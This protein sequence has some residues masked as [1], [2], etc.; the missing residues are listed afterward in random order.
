MAIII[1]RFI[2]NPIDSN[3]FVI[4]NEYDKNC[5]IIDPGTEDCS[6]ILPFLE[7][8][9]LEVEYC[10]LTHEHIDH[11]V[12]MKTLKEKTGCQV[13]CS[14]VCAGYL[15]D[16]KY[17]LSEFEERFEPTNLFPMA[18]IT[19]DSN[20]ELKWHDIEL[21]MSVMP[22]HSR[23]SA[24]LLIGK[25]LFVGDNLIKGIRTKANYFGGSKKDLLVTLE[26][27]IKCYGNSDLTVHCGH[28][29]SSPL[30]EMT[31]E[32]EEQIVFLKRKMK[33]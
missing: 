22:G 33:E 4:S 24:G 18:D 27:L 29:D 6:N 16:T 31:L 20:L 10:F 3:C 30:S 26:K 13:V 19:F 28:F 8:Y 23:G 5:V 25:D 11:I 17:N 12:G 2:N 21:K 14:S 32:I 1:H 7:A 9:G 15:N